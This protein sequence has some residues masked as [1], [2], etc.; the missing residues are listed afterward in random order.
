MVTMMSSPTESASANSAD[1]AEAS[2]ALASAIGGA[3]GALIAVTVAVI[4]AVVI[5]LLITRRGQKGST[6]VENGKKKV[7]VHS[8]TNALYDGK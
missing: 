5:A 3:V 4:V 8:Y 6:K 1:T 7:G 2:N